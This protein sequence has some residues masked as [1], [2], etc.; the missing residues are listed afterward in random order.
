MAGYP[1]VSQIQDPAARNA[2]KN[3]FD[4]LTALQGRILALEQSAVLNTTTLDAKG[5]R[6][7]N[8]ATPTAGS[9]AVTVTYLQQFVQAQVET[10]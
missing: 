7:T 3:V 6:L 4:Q 9:D 10:F 2:V 1:Y 8:L 5:Q